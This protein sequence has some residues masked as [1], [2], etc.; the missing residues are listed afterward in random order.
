VG[1]IIPL[2]IN[3]IMMKMRAMYLAVVTV[4]F[5][6]GTGTSRAQKVWTLEEC[7]QYALDHN[8]TIKRQEL[9]AD[10]SSNNAFQAKMNLLPGIGAGFNHSFNFGRTVDPTTYD[11]VEQNYQSQSMGVG[12]NMTLFHGLQNIN[13]MKRQQFNLMA[14]L[15][16]VEKA[17]NDVTL[18]I[19]TAYL[20]ILFS[21]EILEVAKAQLEVTRLQV[22]KMR[23][24]VE[25]GNK[26]MG[27]LLQIQAQEA[28]DRLEVINASNNLKIAYLTLTQLLDL[29]SA[30]GF[31]IAK[32][33]TAQIDEA[34]V[35]P[36]VEEIYTVAEKEMPQIRMAEYMVKAAQKDL[37]IARGAR[38]P[39]VTLQ[40]QVYTY[41][42]ELQTQYYSYEQQLRNNM[43]K[44]IQF[45]INIP[46]F[47]RYAT[48][49]DISNAKIARND[50][51]LQLREARLDLYKTIQQAHA[52][53][54]AAL[55][56]Y[57]SAA[58]AVKANEEAFKYTEQKFGVGLVSA[59]E[60]NEG[61]KNL[62]KAR[63]DLLQAKYEFIFKTKILAFY[64][65][66]KIE[67]K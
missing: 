32:P 22:E 42:S 17:K 18:N 28:S 30:E 46:L 9:A 27:D 7:I 40:S 4:I 48:Q 65:G 6:A 19:A 66:N 29:D 36:E 38:F 54:V 62:T 10:V 47:S 37:A 1:S 52:D 57:R 5:L 33:V 50:A 31:E 41:Y 51:E 16:Q 60:Y 35:A 55:E 53:A 63:A 24:L 11:F 43:S 21:Q 14:K 44:T 67:L 58:E 20:Q 49:R 2:K 56:K 64:M 39:D 59:V 3:F 12:G 34:L 13:N 25:V 45:G 26:A 61:K 23:K 8:I 15:A